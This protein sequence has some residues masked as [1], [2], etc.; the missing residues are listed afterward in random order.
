MSIIV[1]KYVI[2]SLS[3]IKTLKWLQQVTISIIDTDYYI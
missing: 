1:I 3:T 2:L